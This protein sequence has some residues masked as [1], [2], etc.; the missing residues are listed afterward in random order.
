[1]HGD[2]AT[3]RSPAGR[4]L[5]QPRLPTAGTTRG[6]KVPP[7]LPSEVRKWGGFIAAR[8]LASTVL[9]METPQVDHGQPSL[10]EV[11]QRAEASDDP[12]HRLAV[13]CELA[14]LTD[15]VLRATVST[16]RAQEMSWKA[17]GAALGVTKQAAAKRFTPR[18]DKEGEVTKQDRT[19]AVRRVAQPHWAVTLGRVTILRV[20][21][22]TE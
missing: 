11:A 12:R 8:Q 6:K 22:R 19:H 7:G 4:R 18:A 3:N 10:T 9:R 17:I 15:E 13:L 14:A 5:I 21:R 16:A 2:A 20:W 1:M